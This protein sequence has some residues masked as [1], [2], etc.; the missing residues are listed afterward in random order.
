MI[1]SFSMTLSHVD[2]LA[3]YHRFLSLPVTYDDDKAAKVLVAALASA[4]AEGVRL[5]HR[6]RHCHTGAMVDAE[7]PYT[8]YQT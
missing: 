8:G 6:R 7:V 5:S 1:T 4:S 3:L 2:S